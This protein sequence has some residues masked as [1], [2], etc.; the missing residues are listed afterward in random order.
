[1]TN[2]RRTRTFQTLILAIL[3]FFLLERVWSGKILMYIN[4]RFVILV[5]LAGIGLIALAQAIFAERGK[6]SHTQDQEGSDLEEKE[7]EPHARHSHDS[8]IS[9]VWLLIPLA[10]GLLIPARSLGASGLANRGIQLAAPF[11]VQTVS[12][13]AALETPAGNRTVLDWIRAF[14]ESGDPQ[15]LAN[16]P[17]DVIGFVYHDP[18]LQPGQFLLGRYTVAC[19]IADAAAIGIVVDW[20]D[21]P[22]MQTN[23]WV[24]VKGTIQVGQLDA[25]KVPVLHADQVIPIQEPD[26]PYLF[27]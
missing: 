9:M 14:A 5:V 21:S 17:A 19:C 15:S 23:A 18:R 1:V 6:A 4:Q 22:G 20:P 16:E 11:Q 7:P 13:T 25:Q 24:R 27:P 26:Q 10:F 3:G 2:T 12:N 8:K